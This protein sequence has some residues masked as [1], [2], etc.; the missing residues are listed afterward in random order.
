[1]IICES[2][3]G[4]FSFDAVDQ[5]SAGRGRRSPFAQKPVHNRKYRQM[6]GNGT[7]H[8]NCYGFR[9]DSGVLFEALVYKYI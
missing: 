7:D 2:V 1:M 9:A 8:R 6:N 3:S 4:L 5:R